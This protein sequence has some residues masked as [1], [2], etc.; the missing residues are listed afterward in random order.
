MSKRSPRPAGSAQPPAVAP[1]PPRAT[2]SQASLG[3]TLR[4][5]RIQAGK[6]GSALAREADLPQAQISRFENGHRMPSP[7]QLAKIT[8]ALGVDTRHEQALLARHHLPVHRV[9]FPEVAQEW[10]LELERSH[11]QIK[12]FQSSGVPGALQTKDF[13]HET[14]ER[15]EASLGGAGRRI[16]GAVQVRLKRQELLKDDSHKFEIVVAEAGL[17]TM[18]SPRET[19]RDQLEHIEWLLSGR[20]VDLGVIPF[21][22]QVPVMPLNDFYIFDREKVLIETLTAELILEDAFDIETYAFMF[23]DL[24]KKAVYGGKAAKLV[25]AIRESL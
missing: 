11:D 7:R 9:V 17:R 23:E 19:M 10:R 8:K 2:S 1:P 14:F 13:A 3:A 16:H 21:D 20:R 22:A 15:V 25:G 24:K 5:L 18:N 6:T 4:F 12:I